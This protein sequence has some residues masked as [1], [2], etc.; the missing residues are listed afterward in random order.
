MIIAKGKIKHN[1]VNYIAGDEI[2]DIKKD[3][4]ERLVQLGVAE[5]TKAA[6]PP[7]EDKPPAE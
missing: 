3:E 7:K 1:G 6:K 5:L 2:K 4:A